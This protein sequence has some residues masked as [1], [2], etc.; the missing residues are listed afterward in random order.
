[1]FLRKSRVARDPLAVTMSGVRLG[2]RVLQIGAGNPQI[3]ALIAG[4]TGLT[5]T[6]VVVVGDEDTALRVR[7]AIDGAGAIADVRVVPRAEPSL[8]ESEFDAV[9][10]HDAPH[11]IASADAE[12]RSRWLAV[13]RRVLRGG[14]RVVTIE[15][16]TPTGIRAL[17]RGSR[18]GPAGTGE[19]ES[20]AALRSGGFTSVRL[21]GDREGLRFVEG[22][23]TG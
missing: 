3:V 16:G 9:V 18:A 2:E 23:N 21:L 10:I 22:L 14:G 1:M 8:D 5:G 4:K 12:T 15:A 11:T 6:A 17:F 13:C 19:T 7:R 20:A